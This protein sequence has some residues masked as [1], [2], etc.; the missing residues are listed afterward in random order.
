MTL[1][2]IT[3]MFAVMIISFI[4]MI[5]CIFTDIDISTRISIILFVGSFIL[6]GVFAFIT[7][8]AL[9]HNPYPVLELSETE[10]EFF[11]ENDYSPK[12]V[13]Q[14]IKIRKKLQKKEK[15]NEII[16]ILSL[17]SKDITE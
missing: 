4:A 11:I 14:F 7:N 2:P 13:H 9:K 3:V 16:K 1:L 12:K 8:S 17:I 5:I 10:Y 6:V 15:N